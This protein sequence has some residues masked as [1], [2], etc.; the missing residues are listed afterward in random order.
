MQLKEEVFYHIFQ[1]S[2]FDSNGDGHGDLKGVELKLDYI[3]NLGCTSILLTPL[4]KSI[5]YHN[6]F[7]DDF[8]AIDQKYGSLVDVI[9]LIDAVHSRD[10]KIYLDMEVHYI[11]ENHKWYKDSIGNPQSEYSDYLMYRGP[12]NSAPESIIFHL[13]HL[14]SYDGTCANLTTLNLENEKVK[15]SIEKEFLFWIDIKNDGSIGVDGFRIDHMMDDLDDKGILTD[16]LEKFW[17]PI[18]S[19]TKEGN[20]N[21]SFIGEQGNWDSHPLQYFEKGNVDAMFAF[22]LM[23]AIRNLDKFGIINCVQYWQEQI[24]SNAYMLFVENHDTD[25][26]ASSLDE[27]IDKLK[28]TAILNIFLPGIP[29]IYYGQELGLTGSGGFQAYGNNDGND[30]PRRR[31]FPWKSSLDYPGHTLWYKDS[32]PWWDMESVEKNLNKSLEA[33]ENDENALF[34]FYKKILSIRSEIEV[35]NDFHFSFLESWDDNILG[36][37]WTKDQHKLYILVNLSDMGLE[38]AFEEVASN[39]FEELLSSQET[40]VNVHEHK[41]YLKATGFIIF[42]A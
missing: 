4:Y 37:H 40:Y 15:D 5:F 7:A 20:E 14:D 12:E 30:I 3:K 8:R 9:S 34:N 26:V 23:F 6:Y 33:V 19:V 17:N 27:H 38:F 1:R 39:I 28:L 29:V 35:W 13:E 18:I 22:D 25:R 31:F 42:C 32:G 24:G 10:M 16:L 2:F 41:I 21:V 36:F 11:T